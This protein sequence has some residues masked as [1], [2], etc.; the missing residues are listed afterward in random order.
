MLQM[1]KEKNKDVTMIKKIKHQLENEDEILRKE[2][3]RILINP[4]LIAPYISH[5]YLFRQFHRIKK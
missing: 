1:V 4:E 5:D 2:I 3:E